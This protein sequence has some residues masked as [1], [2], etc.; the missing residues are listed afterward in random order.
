M[1]AYDIVEGSSAIIRFTRGDWVYGP[2]WADMLAYDIVEGSSAIIRHH[3]FLEGSECKG[4]VEHI[5]KWKVVVISYVLEGA[6]CKG[7][8]KHMY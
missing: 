6:G 8:V 4:H 3:M 5:C 7:H 1:L 2:C